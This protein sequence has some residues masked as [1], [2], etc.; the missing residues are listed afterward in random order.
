M[1]LHYLPVICISFMIALSSCNSNKKKETPIETEAPTET[2]E[3]NSMTS[4]DWAGTYEGELPCADCE[5]IKTVVTI[6]QDNTYVAKEVFLGKDTKPEETSGTF[7]WDKDGQRIILSD[8]NRH[9]YF[10]GENT[11]TY[12]DDKG[13]KITGDLEALY[14]LNKVQDQLVGEKWHLVSFRGDEVQFT[15]AKAERAYIQF[16]DDYTITGYTGCNTMQ[17]AYAV[18]DAQNIK[19]SKLVNTLQACPEMETENEFLKA[20]NTTAAFGFEDHALV[21]YDKDHQKLATFKAAN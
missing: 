11:L 8:P 3:D 16:N 10:V 17:G 13:N 7:E 4:L 1:K 6:N 20:I 21:M 18:D 2:L 14:V 12:L 19:F 15:E 5:G 9:S